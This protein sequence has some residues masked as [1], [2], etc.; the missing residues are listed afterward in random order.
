MPVDHTQQPTRGHRF[1]G[2]LDPNPLTLTQTCGALNQS[3]RRRAQHHPTRRGHRLHPLRHPDLPTHGRVTKLARTDLTGDHLTG[4]QPNP[5]PQIEAVALTR[6]VG[7]PGR[8]LLN[9]QG[10]QAGPDG[11]VLQRHRRAEHGH[12][13]VARPL[14]DRAAVAL[15]Y[16]RAT[17]GQVG[18]DLAPPL[19][20][21]RRGDVHRMHYISEQHRDLLVLS[22]CI[23]RSDRCTA[24]VT[25]LRVR[26]QRQCR[27][28]YT[29]SLPRS[30]HTAS[31]PSFTAL[32]CHRWLVNMGEQR[33]H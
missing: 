5:Q 27:T 6:I 3:R 13:S 28:T 29:P 21:H 33:H 10:R 4:V 9:A 2:T 11:V 1:L 17:V 8:F 32:S 30:F 25:K 15:H 22:M 7:K 31:P 18:D 23:V 14:C 26:R 24:L 19:R 12:D 16:S 20:T